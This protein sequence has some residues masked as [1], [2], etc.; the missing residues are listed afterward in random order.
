MSIDFSKA[1]MRNRYAWLREQHP[2]QYREIAAFSS[3][4]GA[5][6]EEV[7]TATR[8]QVESYCVGVAKQMFMKGQNNGAETDPTQTH[9]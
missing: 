7:S 9:R 2:E 3:T 6:D 5:A 1:M 8:A 4:F